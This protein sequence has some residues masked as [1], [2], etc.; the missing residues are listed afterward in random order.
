MPRESKHMN[1][2]TMQPTLEIRRHGD[3]SIDYDFYR[4]RAE[5]RRRIASRMIV[6]RYLAVAGR[7]AGASGSAIA[8]GMIAPSSQ[9]LLARVGA[10]GMLIAV[11]AFQVWA[12][13]SP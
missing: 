9:R 6:K 7:L 2:L 5:R 8:S 1:R 10:A 12:R 4:R 13:A 11:A 3:G